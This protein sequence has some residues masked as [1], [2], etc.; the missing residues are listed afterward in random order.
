MPPP[1]AAPS[2]SLSRRP[3]APESWVE[4]LCAAMIQPSSQAPRCRRTHCCGS[5]QSDLRRGDSAELVR[6]RRPAASEFLQ[7][8]R[9]VCRWSRPAVGFGMRFVNN[10]IRNRLRCALD[11]LEQKIE[12]DVRRPAM[13][14][15]PND[16]AF[17]SRRPVWTRPKKWSVCNGQRF[18]RDPVVVEQPDSRSKRRG[19]EQRERDQQGCDQRPEEWFSVVTHPGGVPRLVA[20]D[21]INQPR[22]AW[23]SGRD[24]RLRCQP[25][26]SGARL[27][28]R[29]TA[30]TAPATA[31]YSRQSIRGDSPARTCAESVHA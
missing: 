11:G 22:S 1:G 24:S 17:E 30:H 14:P 27:R 20:P 31:A 9:V 4:S 25:V 26:Q 8:C 6:E 10:P 12:F 19:I 15:A 23:G 3:T 2:P 21:K 29:P 28:R 16:H 5:D 18:A 7:V 13:S